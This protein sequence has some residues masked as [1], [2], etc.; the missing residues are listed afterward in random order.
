MHPLIRS[1]TV[2]AFLA[3]VTLTLWQS[4]S[5]P[6]RL[7]TTVSVACAGSLWVTF[8]YRGPADN[9]TAQWIL[10]ETLALL[11]LAIPSVRHPKPG[12]AATVA[13]GLLLTIAV[14]PLRI[15]LTLNPPAEQRETV[16]LCV[17]WGVAAGLSIGAACYLRSLDSRRQIAV[18][19]ERRAQRLTVAR[20]LHDFAAHDVTGV[21]VLAQAAKALA[22]DSPER[23][24]ALLPQI[25][26]A[27]VQALK[28]MDRTIRIFSEL[29]GGRD[30][31][32]GSA[33]ERVRPDTK[34]AGSSGRASDADAQV[35]A[36]QAEH[37]GPRA[38]LRVEEVA[39]LVD[40]FSSTGTIPAR[41]DLAPGVLDG[42]PPQISSVGYRVVLEG[43]TNVRRH[44]AS[45]SQ[46]IVDVRHTDDGDGL[47][48]SVAD[49][50]DG[51]PAD[52]APTER[53]GGGTGIA[54]LGRRV[55]AVGGTFKA[56]AQHPVGWRVTA[57]LPTR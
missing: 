25:E 6:W 29:D 47:R 50:G 46:V 9:E 13:F 48:I 15:S 24:L 53:E 41:L 18:A 1:S 27:G 3:T 55:E 17:I 30:S 31:G 16:G 19:A 42:L 40:R 54:D 21:M 32:R 28:S 36:G 7:W 11:V 5:R 14:I 35:G 52:T 56:E 22:K 44:A 23:A 4:G 49:D 34:T 37:S 2:L 39:T 57:V 20:D 38:S 51:Q 45:A 26:T 8:R 33:S 43:L 12:C 10:A